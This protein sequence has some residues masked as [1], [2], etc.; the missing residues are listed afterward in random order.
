MKKIPKEFKKNTFDYKLM[1]RVGPLA[2]YEQFKKKVVYAYEVHK[3]RKKAGGYTKFRNPDGTINEIN[4]VER[5]VLA[6]NEDFGTYGWSFQTY[7]RAL[8]KFTELSNGGKKW[9][10]ARLE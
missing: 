10:K 2:I 8:K 4:F 9:W 3:V 6:S 1:K 7:E 5:E